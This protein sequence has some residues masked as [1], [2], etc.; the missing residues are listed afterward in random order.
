MAC[1]R[2]RATRGETRP[3]ERRE[4][5]VNPTWRMPW[6]ASSTT[7]P[8]NFSV[9]VPSFMSPLPA[10]RCQEKEPWF[11]TTLRA[12]RLALGAAHVAEQ[13]VFDAPGQA[14]QHVE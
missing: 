14:A 10:V 11:D 1:P 4:R 6:C 3:L 9:K 8:S 5:S 7:E 12:C 13:R 2:C